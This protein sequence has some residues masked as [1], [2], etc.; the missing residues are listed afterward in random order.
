MV[1]L[2]ELRAEIDRIDAE[3]IELI[4]QRQDC[5]GRI[6]HQ[7]YLD[8]VSVRDEGRRRAV[9]DRAFDRAVERGVDAMPCS[10]SSSS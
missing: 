4:G 6:A 7:K 2:E 3:I 10:R 5:A 1:T 9:L 8:H